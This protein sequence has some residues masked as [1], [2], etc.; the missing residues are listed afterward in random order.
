[1]GDGLDT[2]EIVFKSNVLIRGVRV[3]VRQTEADQ[4]AWHF[5][6]V[7]HLSYK[8]DGPALANENRL[9]AEALL[10]GGLRLL[11]NR[12]VVRSHPGF[13]SAQDCELAINRFRQELSNVLLDKFGDLVR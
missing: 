5:E 9:P 7:V 1:M 8:R 2:A 11:E 6:G 3:F 12:I 13:S 4:N 10:Q